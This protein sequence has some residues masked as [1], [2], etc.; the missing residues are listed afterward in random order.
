MTDTSHYADA[1]AQLSSAA[2]RRGWTWFFRW[3]DLGNSLSNDDRG[4]LLLIHQGDEESSRMATEIAG[5]PMLA[6]AVGRAFLEYLR[7]DTATRPTDRHQK[8]GA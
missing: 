4:H 1:L 7:W 3:S 8:G 2:D 5:D 6:H